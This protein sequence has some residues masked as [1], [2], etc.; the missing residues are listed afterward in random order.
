MSREIA[1]RRILLFIA[2]CTAP[3]KKGLSRIP[4]LDLIPYS[5]TANMDFEF[6]STI[7]TLKTNIL[8]SVICDCIILI[9]AIVTAGRIL[10]DITF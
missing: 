1:S 10:L 9:G 6:K 4:L 8:I 3:S 5:T 7:C 2:T